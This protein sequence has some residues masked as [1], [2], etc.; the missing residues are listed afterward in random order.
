MPVRGFPTWCLG[1]LRYPRPSG[2]YFAGILDAEVVIRLPVGHTS[3]VLEATQKY[4]SN[5]EEQREKQLSRSGR[6]HGHNTTT[7]ENLEQ[8]KEK[9]PHIL[10]L[11]VE[12]AE[13][14]LKA[15]ILKLEDAQAFLR[16]LTSISK[17]STFSFGV[18]LPK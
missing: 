2:W 11:K 9:A 18:S 17:N 16:R 6:W 15:S 1:T 4:D 12:D 5:P 14:N 3:I 10:P 8:E 13:A 7:K